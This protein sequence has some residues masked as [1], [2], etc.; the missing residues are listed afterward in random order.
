[1]TLASAR[2]QGH[3]AVYDPVDRVNLQRRISRGDRRCADGIS[4]HC[5]GTIKRGHAYLVVTLLPGQNDTCNL[6]GGRIL[7]IASC[8]YCSSRRDRDY[9][10]SPIPLDQEFRY[11]LADSEALERSSR[12]HS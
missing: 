9:L 5:A 3:G 12:A 11:W 1:M 10:L 6:F 7:R 8:A 2:R 4:H